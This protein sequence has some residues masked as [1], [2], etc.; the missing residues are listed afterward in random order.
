[1]RR[2]ETTNPPS[3]S[4]STTGGGEQ[5]MR[6]VATSGLAGRGRGA[7]RD[8]L[9]YPVLR[10]YADHVGNIAPRAV[11]QTGGDIVLL[12]D[13]AD[14]N[15]I[16]EAQMP[17]DLDILLAGFRSG[18]GDLGGENEVG[19][20]VRIGDDRQVLLLQQLG[21]SPR[22]RLAA[23][24]RSPLDAADAKPRAPAYL[25]FGRSSVLQ[26]GHELLGAGRGQLGDHRV[27]AL[28]PIGRRRV[29]LLGALAEPLPGRITQLPSRNEIGR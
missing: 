15:A 3:P 2:A 22:Q 26:Q 23:I 7:A 12:P 27:F 4:V 5:H 6:R 9:H 8:E 21:N 17:D 10:R 25:R 28:F 18:Y 19:L 24:T 16:L 13:G 1:M 29:E 14:L 11:E 20:G